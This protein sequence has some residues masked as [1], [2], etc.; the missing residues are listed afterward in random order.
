[1]TEIPS[2]LSN[3]SNLREYLERVW[4][5]AT[6]KTEANRREITGLMERSDQRALEARDPA[7]RTLNTTISWICSVQNVTTSYY[8][9][10]LALLNLVAAAFE[11][12]HGELTKTQQER[13]AALAENAEKAKQD[14]DKHLAK[15][16]AQLFT[17]EGH[18]AMYGAGKQ[19]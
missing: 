2:D 7:Q 16:M 9:H 10:T 11:A 17:S 15:R 13:I 8:I 19:T 18:E 5:D 1:M 4:N 6:T 14:F 3:P 12:Q